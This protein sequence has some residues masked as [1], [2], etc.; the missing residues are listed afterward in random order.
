LLISENFRI[1]QNIRRCFQQCQLDANSNLQGLGDITDYKFGVA[2]NTPQ[3]S[4]NFDC[5]VYVCHFVASLCTTVEENIF[6]A[7]NCIP[8]MHSHD[9][10]K[11]MRSDFLTEIQ[12]QQTTPTQSLNTTS[13]EVI[14]I[15]DDET[16][17]E[18]ELD[19]GELFSNSAGYTLTHDAVSESLDFQRFANLLNFK[20]TKYNI[21]I[22]NMR[23]RTNKVFF[24]ISIC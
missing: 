7:K 12:K 4:N 23:Q 10:R 20:Q 8:E 9:I 13:T 17:S 5:G 3:Q 6:D 14:E 24:L 22:V 21:V 2:Q 11:Q 19:S 18:A 16:A 15:S 1:L